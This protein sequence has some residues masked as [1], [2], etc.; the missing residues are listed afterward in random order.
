MIETYGMKCNL[1]EIQHCKDRVVEIV[2]GNKCIGYSGTGDT[3][4]FYFHT[5]ESAMMAF[6]ELDDLLSNVSVSASPVYI[7]KT[8]LKGVFNYD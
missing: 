2:K 1:I 4:T 7:D 8:I 3:V 5:A 6:L